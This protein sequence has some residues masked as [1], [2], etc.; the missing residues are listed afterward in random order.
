MD[1]PRKIEICPVPCTQGSIR[2]QLEFTC[3]GSIISK[4][5][6]TVEINY[7]NAMTC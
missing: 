4:F 5:F 1:D 2:N 3:T 7:L 6:L